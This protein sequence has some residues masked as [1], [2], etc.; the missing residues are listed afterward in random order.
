MAP[1]SGV[2]LLQL[3]EVHSGHSAISYACIDLDSAIDVK[4]E[5]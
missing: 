1:K 5:A 2:G 4:L 3:K